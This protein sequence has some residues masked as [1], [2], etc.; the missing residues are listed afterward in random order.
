MANS[1]LIRATL[2]VALIFAFGFAAAGSA[3]AQ[4]D[5]GFILD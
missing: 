2:L 5:Y 3:P 1:T 4:S